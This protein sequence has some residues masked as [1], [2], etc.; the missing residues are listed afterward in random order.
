M[1]GRRRSE[2][3]ALVN[4]ATASPTAPASCAVSGSSQ[5]SLQRSRTPSAAI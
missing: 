2:S 4:S 1:L 3:A 5:P